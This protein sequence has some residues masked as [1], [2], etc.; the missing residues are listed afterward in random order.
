MEMGIRH[1]SSYG[2]WYP[3]TISISME[4][5]KVKYMKKPWVILGIITCVVALLAGCVGDEGYS[6]G[7]TLSNVIDSTRAENVIVELPLEVTVNIKGN[8][9]SK[10]VE[11]IHYDYETVNYSATYET[12]IRPLDKAGSRSSA[13]SAPKPYYVSDEVLQAEA[14]KMMIQRLDL[15]EATEGLFSGNNPE[16]LN[17]IVDGDGWEGVFGGIGNVRPFGSLSSVIEGNRAEIDRGPIDPGTNIQ[18]F[19]T[20]IQSQAMFQA[21]RVH[22]IELPVY[23]NTTFKDLNQNTIDTQMIKTIVYV[24]VEGVTEVDGEDIQHTYYPEIKYVAPLGWVDEGFIDVEIVGTRAEGDD[25][26]YIVEPSRVNLFESGLRTIHKGFSDLISWG[27]W[28]YVDIGG[29]LED[30]DAP[31]PTKKNNIDVRYLADNLDIPIIDRLKG[32][33]LRNFIYELIPGGGDIGGGAGSGI[34]GFEGPTMI[35]ALAGVVIFLGYRRKRGG[36]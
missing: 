19:V 8:K 28:G 20:N 15:G 34:P 5:E 18:A 24:P 10:T 17:S 32:F 11:T 35:A 2:G 4:L 12:T 3:V 6:P 7:G 26:A 30:E 31:V 25:W 13:S 21:E 29:P 14:D 1:R 16:F 27:S 22:I 36:E 33:G 23:I 9:V